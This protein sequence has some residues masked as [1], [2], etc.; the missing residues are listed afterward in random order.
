MILF[1]SA[2]KVISLK[3]YML[4]L[5]WSL[6]KKTRLVIRLQGVDYSAKDATSDYINISKVYHSLIDK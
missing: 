4:L 5:V 2:D 1:Q 3:R 6:M